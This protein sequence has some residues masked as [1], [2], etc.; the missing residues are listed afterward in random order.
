MKLKVIL[1]A[2]ARRLRTPAA[3]RAA[4]AHPEPA[5]LEPLPPSDYPPLDFGA[6]SS[7]AYDPANMVPSSSLAPLPVDDLGTKAHTCV[8]KFVLDSPTSPVLR[9]LGQSADGT[10]LAVAQVLDLGTSALGPGASGASGG[11]S[12]NDEYASGELDSGSEASG[13]SW[14]EGRPRH[15]DAWVSPGCEVLTERLLFAF[16]E[17]PAHWLDVSAFIRNALRFVVPLLAVDLLPS[18]MGAML[19]RCAS[20]AERDSLHLLGPVFCEG[21]AL[22][23]LKPEETQ[24]RFFRVPVWLAYV[25]VSDFP[26]E[27]WYEEKIKECFRGI[28]EVA[29]IDPACLTGEDF[30]PLRLL[31]EVNDRC[32]IPRELSISCKDGVGRSGVVAKILPCKVWPREF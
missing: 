9:P 12:S 16:I 32:E 7:A 4:R 25:F 15:A 24:N 2:V 31:L 11:G 3:V 27:H 17:P 23:L 30:G 14:Q 28:A 8:D 5:A 10:R 13:S 29:E 22:H 18:S 20:R 6:A 26:I 1:R 19:F 21:S